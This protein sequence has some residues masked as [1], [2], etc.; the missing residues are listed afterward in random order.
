MAYLLTI[1][2]ENK[3]IGVN[4]KTRLWLYDSEILFHSDRGELT[5]LID[6][7]SQ[8]EYILWCLHYTKYIF[9]RMFFIGKKSAVSFFMCVL[10]I[11][12]RIVL[13]FWELGFFSTKKNFQIN[14]F[15][16]IRKNHAK[17]R[18]QI[19]RLSDPNHEL[20]IVYTKYWFIPI[21]VLYLT[22]K[23][24]TWSNVIKIMPTW[25]WKPNVVIFFSFEYIPEVW[26]LEKF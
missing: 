23:L 18:Y 15:D 8:N 4:K 10:G 9:V 22:S 3:K 16:I 7:H 12:A 21:W 2:Y 14:F 13:I 6:Y 26:I 25:I 19:K 17:A 1:W 20:F 11:A 24:I 5:L